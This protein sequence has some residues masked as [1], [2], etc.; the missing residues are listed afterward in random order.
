MKVI[1]GRYRDAAELRELGIGHAGENVMVHETVQLVDVENISLNSNVR[2][3]PFCILSAAGGSIKI[4]NYVHIA[5]HACIFGGAGVVMENFTGISHGVKIYSVSDNYSGVALTNP[6]VP[7][8]YGYHDRGKIT[9]RKHVI[10]GSGSVILPA[11]TI[12]EGSAVGALSL[13]TKSLD[14]WG[15]YI[16]CP[17]KR[18]KDRKKHLLE[19]EQMLLR[20]ALESC[21]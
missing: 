21:D 20:S 10:V 1:G 16:G 6:T 13:V 15:M 11:V 5:A 3:D 14:E 2:I 4:G 17:V 12:G 9:L 8:E 7:L 18:L 19:K